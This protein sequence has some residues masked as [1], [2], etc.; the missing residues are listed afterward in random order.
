MKKEYAINFSEYEARAALEN[1]KSQVR[2]IVKPVQSTPKIPPETMRPWYNQGYELLEN[3]QEEDDDG[4]P[5]WVGEHPEY[6]HRHKWFTCP[7]G[8]EGYF[9]DWKDRQ[10]DVMRIKQFLDTFKG[11]EE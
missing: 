10:K 4:R 7:W 2:R 9:C 8:K 1:R 5:Y 3:G 11:A 6:P